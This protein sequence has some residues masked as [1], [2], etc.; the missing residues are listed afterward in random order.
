MTWMSYPLYSVWRVGLAAW[1]DNNLTVLLKHHT[2]RYASDKER[3]HPFS[4]KHIQFLQT[5][6]MMFGRCRSDPPSLRV[7]ERS[8]LPLRAWISYRAH[9]GT[10]LSQA[11]SSVAPVP[12]ALWRSSCG[13]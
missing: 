7:G 13:A 9:N 1:T 3:A 12:L 8:T 10:M 6:P 4:S 5:H 2:W 11:S